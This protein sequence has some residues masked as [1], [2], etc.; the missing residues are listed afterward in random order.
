MM[1]G[2]KRFYV[3][4]T[5]DVQVVPDAELHEIGYSGFQKCFELEEAGVC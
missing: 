1:E 2:L 5:T 3:K 4:R